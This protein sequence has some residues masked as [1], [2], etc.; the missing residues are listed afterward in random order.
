MTAAI[1][2]TPL[3]ARVIGCLLEKEIATPEQYPLSLNALV[4][5]CNQK[6]NRDP[7]MELP[8]KEVEHCLM[9]LTRN[10][11]VVAETGFGNRVSKYRHRFCNSEFGSLKFTPQEVAIVCELLLRDG[12]MPGE[13]RSRASRLAAFKDVEELE[14]VL[15]GLASREDGPFVAKLPREPGRRESRYVHLFRDNV[16]IRDSSPARLGGSSAV[17]ASASATA[18]AAASMSASVALAGRD[19]AVQVDRLNRLEAEV[20]ALREEVAE[21]RAMLQRTGPASAPARADPSDPSD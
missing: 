3:E 7:V 21:L 9:D 19:G 14:Q 20:V 17:G 8:E 5:G 10:R 6:N 4:N 2:L 1:A 11:L 12:Q 13:L 15:D 16:P 18:S